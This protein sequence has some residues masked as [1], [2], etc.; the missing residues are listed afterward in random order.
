MREA[1]AER[2]IE[3]RTPEEIAASLADKIR[4]CTVFVGTGQYSPYKGHERVSIIYVDHDEKRDNPH[5]WDRFFAN[6]SFAALCEALRLYARDV[7]VG[8]VDTMYGT[9]WSYAWTMPPSPLRVYDRQ[10]GLVVMTNDTLHVREGS[11]WTTIARHDVTRVVG[12]LSP[13]WSKHEVRIERHNGASILI[14]ENEEY[15]ALADPTYDGI[16]LMCDAAWVGRLGNAL[17]KG[18]GVPYSANDRALE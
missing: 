2:D 12:W 14:A 18:I 17:A 11:S 15:M 13:D 7:F 9:P 3:R 5:V 8:E 6:A 10:G 16:N 4:G 1:D